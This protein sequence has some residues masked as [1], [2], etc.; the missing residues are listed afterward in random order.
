MTNRLKDF[1]A[2]SDAATEPLKFKLHDEEFECYPALQGKVLLDLVANSNEDSGAAMARTIDTF[3]K[4]TLLPESY[5]RF[6]TLLQDPK[7]IVSV[8]TLGE[9]T[10][11]LV[12]EYS[13][14]PNQLP[15]V[16]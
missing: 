7:R 3:F 8:D 15:E 4:M 5:G 12:E 14:R 16:S 10:G 2:G 1:G 6:D 13:G 9:I 11:W